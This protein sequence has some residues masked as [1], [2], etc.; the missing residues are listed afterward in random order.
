MNYAD[1]YF[2]SGTFLVIKGE[3]MISDS[4]V[5]QPDYKSV[6]PGDSVNLS[7]SVHTGHVAAEHTRVMWLK[8]SDHSA[9]TMIHYSKNT[10]TVCRTTGSEETTCVYSLHMRNLSSDDAGTYYCAVTLCGEIL[11]G[12]GT[13]ISNRD[14]LPKSA[15]LSPTVIALIVSNIFL[16]MG[17]LLFAWTLCKN[18]NNRTVPSADRSQ[19]SILAAARSSDESPGG[20]QSGDTIIYTAV[21]PAPT[22]SSVTVGNSRE[23]V[24]Y[25]HVK[26]CQQKQLHSA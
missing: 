14:I 24:V 6:Q 5:Q 4:V 20:N 26:Y 22:S 21:C 12:H 3:K 13:R 23:T 1:I 25:S 17:T 15:D 7:C 2:G 9:P 11:F 18:K 8:S 10:N 16:G 19:P